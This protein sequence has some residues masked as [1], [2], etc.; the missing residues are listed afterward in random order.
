M[1]ICRF[2]S[3]C[4]TVGWIHICA[5]TAIT[6]IKT[7]NAPK[8]EGSYSQG[9][10]INLSQAENLVFV[11]GQI[12]KNP[13]TGEIIQND[14][15]AATNQ[16]MDNIE[17]VLREAGSDWEHVVRMD[18]FLKDYDRDWDA[19]NEEYG[20]RFPNKVYPARQTVG[21]HMDS[22]LLIEMSCIAIVPKK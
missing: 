17:A 13:L 5:A 12:A 21:V 6:E 16:T 7:I 22:S 3:V 14:I 19:M 15:R 4:L 18:V 20:K 1:K 8:P 9:L 11:G 2:F 10:S